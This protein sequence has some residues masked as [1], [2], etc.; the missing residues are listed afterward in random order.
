M[1]EATKRLAF[2]ILL[3]VLAAALQLWS[4]RHNRHQGQAR[5]NTPVTI[6]PIAILQHS[7]NP[8]MEEIHAG[9]LAGLHSK[10][11]DD[12]KNL[13]ITTYNPEGDLPTGNLMAQKITGGDYRLA[14]SISTVMLQALANANRNGRV[15]HVF[16]A[17]TSP[18]AAGVGIKAL[19][20]L[21]KPPHLTGIGTPQPVAD[22]FRLAKQL[23]P[24]LKTVGVVWN[25]A[26]VNSEFCTKQA[27]AV[28]GELGL[29]LL[30]A[31]VEQAKD[32]REAAE[33]LVA[34][35]VEAFWTGGDATVNATVDSLIEVAHNAHIPVFS[36]ISG[37]AKHGGLFDLGA[38]YHEVGEQIGRIAADVLNGANPA[39]LPVK[40]YVPKRLLLNEKTLSS[41]RDAWQFNPALYAQ[42]SLVIDK[43][44]VETPLKPA[45]AALPLPAVAPMAMALPAGRTYKIGVA[46]FAPE[47]GIDSVMAGL[48]E[49]LKALGLEEGR[50]L[51]FQTMHAQAEIAQIPTIGQVL[52]NSD[53]DA[54]VTLTTPVLQGVG[55]MAK[56]KPVAFTYVTDPLAAGAG[57]SFTEHLPNLTGIGSFPPVADML[58]L[59]RK[60]LPGV[61]S[62]GTLYNPSEANSVKVAAV[63]RELC[64]KASIT[65][66]EIPINT[67]ADV[68]QA[69]QAAVARKVGAI[70]AVG[71]N[72][73]YQGVDAI[74]KIAKDANIPLILD[75]P[76]FIGH[77]A[78]MVVGVDYKESGRAVAEP[79]VQLLA[80][81]KPAGIPFRNVSKKSIVLNEASAQ[82][83]HITFPDELRALAVAATDTAP[84]P[85]AKPLDHLWKIKRILYVETPPAE[86]ALHG[87]DE[88][89]KAAGL[90]AGRDFVLSDA[91]AQGDMTVLSGL[92]DAAGSDGT[93][94]L[95]TLSTPTLQTV[96]HKVKK[97]PIVFT[98]VANPIIA[99]AGTD[100]T[101]HLPNVTGVY[102]LAPFQ[103]MVAL[104]K[105]Y[106]PQLRRV[107][108]LFTPGE[109]NSVYNMEAFEKA[110]TA[111][112]LSVN[113]MPVN[114]ASELPN[115][116]LAM[117]SQPIDAWVQILDNQIVSGFTAITQAATR[118][119]KPL[120]TFTESGVKQGAAV[121]YSMDYYQAG[122][123]AALKAADIMRGTP[124]AAIAFS[125]PSKIRL[126]I[127]EAH[128]KALQLPLPVGLV[129]KADLRLP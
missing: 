11:L 22:I 6:I 20:S 23:N 84:T 99:G 127:S 27:R 60:V 35:G 50:N 119:K 100:D 33:S 90:Q 10:G 39:T 59:T 122:F 24:A 56:H 2:S 34:R 118:A 13:A 29:T 70:V 25:P 53:V 32:V 17:V 109:D 74:A 55:M 40:D 73:M 37:H 102:T 78:L 66:E 5:T 38:D 67:T 51:S 69:A 117:A 65:L 9:I 96:L 46:Y 97:I 89:F 7:S 15:G 52:D 36:N 4:D 18:V 21:D 45:N 68:V 26:E 16:G 14:V 128:A 63:L 30:E 64:Q 81:I 75:Q 72:T 95:M 125:K 120:F 126:I 58:E 28:A 77:D 48:R 129:N 124:P 41:L 108:T 114:S 88:G 44:G 110:A 19:D 104:L 113:K 79:L 31:P 71:D 105:Q 3:I 61:R 103:E 123:D 107:G 86:E 101:H 1:T 98:F 76:D 8:M 85:P 54:I 93:E 12:G 57:K 83:L 121:A 116:A 80:G 106:F 82:R 115:A 49:G 112:G 111:Q 94:L 92:A 62:L 43:N 91:S 47:P 42:A 87:I